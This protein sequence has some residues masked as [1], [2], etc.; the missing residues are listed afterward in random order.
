MGFLVALAWVSAGVCTL[1]LTGAAF[2]WTRVTLRERREERE[3]AAWM[4]ANYR[5]PGVRHRTRVWK[6]GKGD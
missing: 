6:S 2:R 3:R 5:P 1:T 4:R